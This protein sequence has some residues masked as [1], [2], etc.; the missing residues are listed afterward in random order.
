MQI[1]AGLFGTALLLATVAAAIA[2]VDYPAQR[3]TIVAGFPGFAASGWIALLVPAK[4]SPEIAGKLNTAVNEILQRDDVRQRLE[5][6]GF[7]PNTQSLEGA[8]SFL[9]G[10]IDNW[11]RMVKAI[12][13]TIR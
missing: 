8:A 1:R 12:G 6:V 4:T 3:I 5:A 2:Q 9:R 11:S 10:E 13:L 7:T